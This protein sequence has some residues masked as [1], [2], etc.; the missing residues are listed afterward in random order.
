MTSQRRKNKVRDS[1][2][3]SLFAQQSLQVVKV[4]PHFRSCRAIFIIPETTVVKMKT[5]TPSKV[6]SCD[7]SEI[8]SARK[9]R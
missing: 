3:L 6:M 2:G 1:R 5:K 9:T 7:W 8:D 4:I